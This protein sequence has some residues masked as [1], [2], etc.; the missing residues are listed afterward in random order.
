MPPSQPP[1]PSQN[2]REEVAATAP[3]GKR[4]PAATRGRNTVRPVSQTAGPHS[5]CPGRP[6]PGDGLGDGKK[7]KKKSRV[8]SNPNSVTT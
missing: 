5:V 8:D 3:S 1:A 4:T 7:R 6:P 2:I